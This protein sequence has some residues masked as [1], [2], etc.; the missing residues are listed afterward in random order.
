MVNRD[1]WANPTDWTAVRSW[2]FD[3]E[4]A[5]ERLRRQ[6]YAATCWIYEGVYFALLSVYEHPGDVSEGT[7]TDRQRRHERDVMEY[8]LATSRDGDA[9]DLGWVYA[10]RP[11]VPRGGDGAFD[12]DLL[13]PAST[14]VTH[15]DRH[16]LY[17]AGGDERHG[18]DATNPPVRF[19]RR[20]AIGLA[21]LRLDGFV[22]LAAGEQQ[23]TVTTR[24]FVLEG[25]RLEVNPTPARARPGSK[26]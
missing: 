11:I 6:I 5:E 10:G 18:T 16:W 17:Y 7:T 14:I 23:G 1:L 21:H 22:A 9:W 25:S 8:Y 13:L 3:R 2:I 24:P 4:G 15:E 12:K 26:C 20:H 19:D